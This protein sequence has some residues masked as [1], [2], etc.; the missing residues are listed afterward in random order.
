M[1]TA[2]ALMQ[3]IICYPFRYLR[4]DATLFLIE[5]ITDS[6]SVLCKRKKVILNVGSLVFDFLD[7]RLLKTKHLL[8]GLSECLSFLAQ[9]KEVIKSVC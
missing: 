3:L 7:H 8:I 6:L 1:L 5:K 9:P 4:N 2:A